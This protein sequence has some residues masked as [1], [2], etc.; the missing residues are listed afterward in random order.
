[1]GRLAARQP[2][3][4]TMPPEPVFCDIKV[5]C[6]LL[7]NAKHSSEA[8]Y[9]T[10]A[11]ELAHLYCGHLGIPNSDW[12]PDRRGLSETVREFETESVAFLVCGRLGIKNPAAEY[13]SQYVNSHTST[14]AISLNC[15]LKSAG[16]IEQ[17]GQSRL[18]LRKER[19]RP[20]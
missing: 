8:K 17:M 5:R 20:A 14:P 3:N 7:L 15:V 2:V 10:L 1:M 9:A 12:W 16:L 11:H 6:E 19:S 13:L 4:L 18:N